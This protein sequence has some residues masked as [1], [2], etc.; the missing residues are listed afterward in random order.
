MRGV[1]EEVMGGMGWAHEG[2]NVF[3]P[4]VTATVR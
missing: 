1:L 2:C 4:P 3:A